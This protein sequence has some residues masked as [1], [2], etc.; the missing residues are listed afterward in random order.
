MI[1]T[2]YDDIIKDI[3]RKV[4]V[5]DDTCLYDDT[6]ESSFWHTWDYLDVCARNGIVLNIEKFVYCKEE[7]E[8]AGL[9]LTKDGIASSDLILSAIRDFPVPNNLTDARAWFGPVNQV[10]WAYATSKI[11]LPFRDLVKKHSRFYWDANLQKL[12][13]ESKKILI[14]LVHEGVRTYDP[15]LPTFLQTD[16]SRKSI[17]YLLCRCTVN[18]NEQ[19]LQC[20]AL[21]DGNLYMR[22]HALLKV[23]NQVIHLVRERL[24]QYHGLFNMQFFLS[25]VVKISLLLLTTSRYWG[26]SKIV[27]S[28]QLQTP[29]YRNSKNV[30]SNII[31]KHN[32]VLGNGT[33][34]PMLLVGT[35][36]QF[37]PSSLKTQMRKNCRQ[38]MS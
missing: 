37:W 29:D 9:K 10:A 38:F 27:T 22:L 31:S 34:A 25:Q 23:L 33:E 6:I 24:W 30:P 2:R 11:M 21:M 36:H 1:Y 16:W 4:K 15:S 8:F 12:F 3:P 13:E 14:D 35:Q 28:I 32:I 26:C 18:V 19:M 5:I 20:V 17:G 7:V